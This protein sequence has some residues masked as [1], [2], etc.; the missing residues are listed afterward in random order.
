MAKQSQSPTPPGYRKKQ[1]AFERQAG[2][3]TPKKPRRRSGAAPVKPRR[4]K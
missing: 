3:W 2:I 1:T 4:T